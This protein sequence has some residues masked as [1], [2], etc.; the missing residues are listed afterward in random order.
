MQHHVKNRHTG[1]KDHICGENFSLSSLDL[2]QIF[3]FPFTELCG[4]EFS[5]R[6]TLQKHLLVHSTTKPYQCNVCF[7][8]FRHKS[9]LSRHN[10]IHLKVTECVHCKKSF[11]YE[12]FL[13]KHLLTAHNGQDITIDYIL[14]KEEEKD[15]C[16][17]VIYEPE[18]TQV[19]HQVVDDSYYSQPVSITINNIHSYAS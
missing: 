9:S 12:S 10:K 16:I 7:M 5:D 3:A 11:R 18:Q 6:T 15:D 13:K 1:V 17:D 4:K 2:I 14:P 8:S 19:I